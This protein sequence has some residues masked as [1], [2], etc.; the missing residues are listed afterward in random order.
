MVAFVVTVAELSSDVLIKTQKN[1]ILA[2]EKI[3]EEIVVQTQIKIMLNA[4]SMLRQE[5][6]ANYVDINAA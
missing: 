4:E 6:N 2:A 5:D 3:E 1:Q